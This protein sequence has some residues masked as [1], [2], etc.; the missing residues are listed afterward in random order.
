M[1]LDREREVVARHAG[2]VVG[3]ADQPPAAAVGHDLDA[4]RAGV[5]RVLDQFLDH[6]RRPLDHLAGGDAVDDAF[7]ELADGHRRNPSANCAVPT[8]QCI[9]PGMPREPGCRAATPGDRYSATALA[10]VITSGGD[11]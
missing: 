4:R 2:A 5:E 10:R 1:A 8:A 9:G 7:G 3:D 11:A 6:A